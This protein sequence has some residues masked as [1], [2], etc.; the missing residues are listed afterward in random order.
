MQLITDASTDVPYPTYVDLVW[1]PD[2]GSANDLVMSGS[3]AIVA[4]DRGLWKSTNGLYTFDS[5][6]W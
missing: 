1:Y 3:S 2:Q 4:T 6:S 5:Q